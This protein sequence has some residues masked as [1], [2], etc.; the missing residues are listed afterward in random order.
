MAS[1]KNVWLKKSMVKSLTAKKFGPKSPTE[2]ILIL[3]SLSKRLTLIVRRQQPDDKSQ[4]T[5]KLSGD[6]SICKKAM[7]KYNGKES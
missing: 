2:M 1:G 6:E 7:V 4:N 5:K 3:T